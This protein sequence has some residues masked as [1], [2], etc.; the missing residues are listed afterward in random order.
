MTVLKLIDSKM[1][2]NIIISPII[3]KQYFFYHAG[4]MH[5]G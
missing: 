4:R 2:Q 1:V 3:L 5:S